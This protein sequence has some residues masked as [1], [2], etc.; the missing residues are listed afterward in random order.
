VPAFCAGTFI[1]SEFQALSDEK[2]CNEAT[3]FPFH[4]YKY[5][6]AHCQS[7]GFVTTIGICLNIFFS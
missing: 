4:E 1:L 7:E 3:I 2:Y 6:A 5:F